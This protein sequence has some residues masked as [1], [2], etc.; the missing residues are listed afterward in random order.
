MSEY[1]DRPRRTLEE[2]LRLRTGRVDWKSD[3]SSLIASFARNQEEKEEKEKK[4]E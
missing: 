1:L 2:V 3:T 4:D